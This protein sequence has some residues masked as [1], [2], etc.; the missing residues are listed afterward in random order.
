ME[1]NP[2]TLSE[3]KKEKANNIIEIAK[4]IQEKLP[5]AEKDYQIAVFEAIIKSISK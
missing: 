3:Y 2:T 1:E 5:V 4:L